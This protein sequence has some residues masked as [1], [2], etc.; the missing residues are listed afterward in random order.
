MTKRGD[1]DP[2]KKPPQHN[3]VTKPGKTKAVF[4]SQKKEAA[5]TFS[6]AKNREDARVGESLAHYDRPITTAEARRM[7][8]IIKAD[9]PGPDLRPRR[10]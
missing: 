1:G 8:E 9:R 2:G 10:R 7:N 5:A 4:Q 6:K 3:V